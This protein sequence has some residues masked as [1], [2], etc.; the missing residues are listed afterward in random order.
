MER[1]VLVLCAL[2]LNL[3]LAG[4]PKWFEALGLGRLTR[5]PAVLVRMLERRL[6]RE[7]R[8]SEERRLRGALLVGMALGGGLLVGALLNW[9]FQYN[10]RFIELLLVALLLP[11]RPSWDTAAQIRYGLYTGNP[12]M[13]RAA[14][15]H[16]VWRHHAL[17]DEHGL[18]RAGIELL[19]VHFAEKIF[20]PALAYV[21][22]GLPGLFISKAVYVLRETLPR[23]GD[24]FARA[25]QAAHYALHYIPARVACVL[26]LAAAFFMPSV[27]AGEAVRKLSPAINRA[28]PQEIALLSAASVLKLSLGGPTSAYAQAWIGDGTPKPTAYDVKRALQL[29]AF[30]HLLLLV[31]FGL[32]L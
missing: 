29:F 17:L 25:T 1:A 27:K 13:A 10:L 2:L 4:P 23:T 30:L 9:L 18:A 15:E 24:E 6:N 31:L 5:W 20:A 7:R 11:V 16:T 32:F 22:F 19:A 3:L 21:L 26:F 14:L 28:A 12:S 8:S